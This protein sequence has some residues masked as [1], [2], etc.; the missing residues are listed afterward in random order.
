MPEIY[1]KIQELLD[2]GRK[3]ALCLVIEDRGHTPRKTGTKM[4]VLDDGAIVGTIGGGLTESKLIEKALE[5]IKGKSPQ[6][7]KFELTEKNDMLCGGVMEFYIERIE[8]KKNLFIFGAGH[9]GRKLA[10]FAH[11]LEFKI[12]LI[13]ERE[14]IFD[15]FDCSNYTIINKN[16]KDVF[17]ELPFN[18]Q[19]FIAAI[20]HIHQYDREVIAQCA[21]KKHAYLGMIGSKRKIEKS[22]QVFLEKKLLTEE[23]MQGID[24]PMGLPI[25]CQT[26]EEIAISI[27]AKLIDVRGKMQK[28]S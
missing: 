26:P 5:V 27:L 24:W 21:K 8:P 10:E 12:T 16:H 25:E 7:F 11:K 6:K 3:L 4:L 20:S 18:D 1:T 17:D 22:K 19:T 13:D 9:I 28:L 14:G 23:E 2:K 15:E